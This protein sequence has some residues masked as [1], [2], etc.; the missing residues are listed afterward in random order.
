MTHSSGIL[1]V[2]K[3]ENISSAK[4]VSQ[5]KR[6]LNGAKVGH[7]GTLDPFATGVLVVCSQKATRLCDF[8]LHS[9]KTY[10]ADMILGI[11]TDTQDKTGQI[12]S[13]KEGFFFSKTEIESVLNLFVGKIEQV[14]PVFSAL[15]HQGQPLYKLAR[16]GIF[17]QKPARK[18]TIYEIRLL[19]IDFPRVQFEIDCSSGTY[20]RT[21]AAD[22]GQK[23]GCGAYL[24]D[25][26]RTKSGIFSIS[27]AYSLEKWAEFSEKGQLF[28]KI[29]PMSS[30][31]PDFPSIVVSEPLLKKIKHGAWL[32]SADILTC[33]YDLILF[34][35]TTDIAKLVD[36]K[37]NLLALIYLKN[38]DASYPYHSVY[39]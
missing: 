19:E 27:D 29:L 18:I 35:N 7:A 22:I 4:A 31:L 16:K 11:E 25:L 32:T 17:V 34:E 5:I 13:Q 37:N 2:D 10:I 21:L 9:R 24:S 20:I 28:E 33:Q 36:E 12:L 1:L 8:F 3:P 23:L 39:I 6:L 14:P 15:K 26:R 38:A 30:V